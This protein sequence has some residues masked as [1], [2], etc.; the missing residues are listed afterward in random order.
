MEFSKYKAFL[1]LWDTDEVENEKT[2]Q[3]LL[4]TYKHTNMVAMKVDITFVEYSISFSL[5]NFLSLFFFFFFRNPD[6]IHRAADKI[7][8]EI[9]NVSIIVQNAGRIRLDKCFYYCFNR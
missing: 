6:E 9:G 1:C 7:R 4:N 8:R 5:S 2:Y 3:L